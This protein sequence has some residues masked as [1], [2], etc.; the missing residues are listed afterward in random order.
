MST[1]KAGG[2]YKNGRDLE[3]KRLGV[4]RFRFCCLVAQTIVIE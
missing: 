4:K 2:S 1:K 3:S